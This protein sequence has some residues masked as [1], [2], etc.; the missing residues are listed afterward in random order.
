MI[1]FL[2]CFI[3]LYLVFSKV[4]LGTNCDDFFSFSFEQ[5]DKSSEEISWSE[6]SESNEISLH[7]K[8]F[9]SY[10][11]SDHED[12]YESNIID[13]LERLAAEN[14]KKLTTVTADTISLL[15]SIKTPRLLAECLYYQI[16][17][18]FPMKIFQLTLKRALARPK[19][20]MKWFK[21][22]LSLATLKKDSSYML[23]L[24]KALC[25]NNNISSL[26]Y[27]IVF[28]GK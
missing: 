12:A 25:K 2:L 22:V 20:E 21:A 18:N 26:N 5:T 28:F 19:F 10:L 23:K 13:N 27:T 15:K 16:W 11:V 24:A 17:Y 14:L 6:N 7:G 3:A 4:S 1:S 9:N 8:N